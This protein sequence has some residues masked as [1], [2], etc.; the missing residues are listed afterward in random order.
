MRETLGAMA[1]SR[2]AAPPGCAVSAEVR[3]DLEQD[4]AA[5]KLGSGNRTAGCG[6]ADRGAQKEGAPT[7]PR[8]RCAVAAAAPR[9]EGVHLS[10]CTHST[11]ARKISHF[12]AP[13]AEVAPAVG[14]AAASC[15]VHETGVGELLLRLAW[16][17]VVGKDGG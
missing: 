5:T 9:Q 4:R 12:F 3:A 8:M 10:T 16:P 14:A 1:P 6:A 15:Q 17:P 7:A 2:R 11:S 13:G